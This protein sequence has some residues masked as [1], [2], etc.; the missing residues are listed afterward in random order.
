VGPPVVVADPQEM[1]QVIQEARLSKATKV[2]LSILL[3][4]FINLKCSLDPA[5]VPPNPFTETASNYVGCNSG[6]RL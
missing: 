4:T 6:I 5:L 1:Q 2:T 3:F